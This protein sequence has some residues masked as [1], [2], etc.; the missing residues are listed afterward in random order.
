MENISLKSQIEDLESDLKKLRETYNNCVEAIKEEQSEKYY[1]SNGDEDTFRFAINLF[2]GHYTKRYYDL[3]NRLRIDRAKQWSPDKKH[4]NYYH[5]YEKTYGGSG[6]TEEA[7]LVGFV[8]K[9]KYLSEAINEETY[10]KMWFFYMK[11]NSKYTESF[12]TFKK[13]L[14][15][16]K[17]DLYSLF[18]NY[19][20]EK[21]K[22]FILEVINH[23]GLKVNDI[24]IY[25]R[26]IR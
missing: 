7:N 25:K 23:K 3:P 10:K 21:E 9:L 1:S 8:C 19:N 14:K 26:R 24:L 15:T 2:Y 18:N 5:L 22:D 6:Y 16:S 17:I 4:L 20:K 13:D 11:N 12:S